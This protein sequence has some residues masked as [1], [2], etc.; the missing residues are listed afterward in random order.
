MRL[1]VFL[2]F[3]IY[4]PFIFIFVLFWGWFCLLFLR[5]TSFSYTRVPYTAFNV[6]LYTYNS[7]QC[8]GNIAETTIVAADTLMSIH[9]LAK[10]VNC[11]RIS[12]AAFLFYQ[13]F[14][15]NIFGRRCY[16][17]P[18]LF[19]NRI[20]GLMGLKL[21]LS[22]TRKRRRPTVI[23]LKKCVEDSFSD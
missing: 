12:S 19:K 18:V 17:N 8:S 7:W 5:I 21:F 13:S 23:Y 10:V 11:W 20:R 2:F 3:C 15:T 22:Y 1:L 14:A 16:V 9:M 6:N 4:K